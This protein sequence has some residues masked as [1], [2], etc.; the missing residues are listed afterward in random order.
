MIEVFG[1]RKKKNAVNVVEQEHLHTGGDIEVEF[2][3]KEVPKYVEA[4]GAMASAAQFRGW[5]AI[6]SLVLVLLS[7]SITAWVMLH[8]KPV[9]LVV[10]DGK[11]LYATPASSRALDYQMFVKD[12]LSLFLNYGPGNVQTNF[13]EAFKL[14]TP[15]FVKAWRLKMGREFV[16]TVRRNNVVQSTT[17]NGVELIKA[18]NSGFSVRVY[19]TGYRASSLVKDPEEERKVFVVEV[20]KGK[21]TRDNPWGLYVFGLQEER[22]TKE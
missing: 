4:W 14:A 20:V 1:R 13:S 7:S 12:F 18:S 17:I 6:I 16:E 21:I 3:K 22:T 8:N 9:Y 2:Q 11:P 10:Q 19:A 15:E 5:V